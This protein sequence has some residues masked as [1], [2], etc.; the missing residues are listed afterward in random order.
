MTASIDPENLPPVFPVSTASKV[1]G[2]GRNQQY[3]LIAAGKYP[4][5][6]LEIGGRFRVSRYDLL[7]YLHAEPARATA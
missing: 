6:V 7:A 3:A 4:V 1:L 2:I 5:R